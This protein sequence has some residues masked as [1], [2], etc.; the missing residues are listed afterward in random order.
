MGKK[1][2][3]YK[4]TIYVVLTSAIHSETA[5]ELIIYQNDKGETFARPREM[6]FEDVILKDGT[7]VKRFE[8][9]IE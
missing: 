5:E 2:R 3:H 8:E 9:I 1:F 6:F 4:G 7:R